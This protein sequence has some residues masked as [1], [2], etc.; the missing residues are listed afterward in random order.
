MASLRDRM[1]ARW[2][3][4]A[5]CLAAAVLAV[6]APSAGAHRPAGRRTAAASLSVGLNVGFD[7]GG[8]SRLIDREIAVAHSLHANIVRVSV[9]WYQFA[10]LGPQTTEPHALAT[11][12]RLVQDAYNRGIRVILDVDATPCWASSA[13]PSLM[14]ACSPYSG[15]GAH[16]WPP[17]NAAAYAAFVALLARRYGTRLAA[18]EVWN[19]P[20]QRNEAYFAGPEKAVR[21]AALLRAA[22]P[23]IKQANPRVTVLGGSIVGANGLFLKALY[24]AGIKGYYDALAVHY[25]SLTLAAVRSIHE[26]QLAN[27]DSTPLWLDEFGWSSCY[28][29]SK[30]QQE[31]ACVSASVQAANLLDTVHALAHLPYVSAAVVYKLWDSPGEQFGVLTS[32]GTRKRSFAALARAFAVPLRPVPRASLRLRRAHGRIVASGSAPVGDFMELEAFVGTLLRYKVL[33]TLN[34][35]NRYSIRLPAALGTHDLRVQV[36]QYGAGPARAAHA[37][38]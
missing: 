13:P 19:E 27:G 34:R 5:A 16:A 4:P 31:Q 38:I 6:L 33:F 17:Q 29:R 15:G 1:S 35:F 30:K 36:Y 2:R 25:Y 11:L 24:A 8:P 7:P 22:Y 32:S 12:D 9:P 26:V 18:I 37:G 3:A 20:D 23:A 21:Y 28:P 10:P 14:R